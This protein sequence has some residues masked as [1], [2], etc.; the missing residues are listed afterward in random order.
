MKKNESKK[1]YTLSQM[2]LQSYYDDAV[3]LYFNDKFQNP[4]AWYDLLKQIS[5]VQKMRLA[6]AWY[7]VL[8]LVFLK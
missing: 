4:S 1:L 6:E 2:G 5:Q 7:H 8:Y 3:M